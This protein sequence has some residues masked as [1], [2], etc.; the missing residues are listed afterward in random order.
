MA[1][2]HQKIYQL[3]QGLWSKKRIYLIGDT[4]FAHANI[5]RYCDRPFPNAQRPNVRLMNRVLVNNWN[6]TVKPKD[7]V[8]FL[9]DWAFG[10][11]PKPARYWVARSWKR[12]LSGHIISI[13]GNHDKK[14]KGVRFY[15]WGTLY[16]RGYKFLL[17]HRPGL[18]DPGQ[19]Q[20]QKRKLAKWHGWVIHG[21][22]HNNNM[23]NYPFINGK[24]KTINVG[25]ELTNYKPVSLDFLLS[26]NIDSIK[27]METINSKPERW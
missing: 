12:K 8:Y 19:T 13:R 9:G 16:Y 5:I 10:K 27:R 3:I 21:H 14:Q 2:I 4:H 18:N 17:I 22:K 24:R 26:L 7:T 1:K 20:K 25:V 6:N 15:N 11:G 23:R